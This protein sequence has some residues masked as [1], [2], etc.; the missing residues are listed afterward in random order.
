MVILGARTEITPEGVDALFASNAARFGKSVVEALHTPERAIH[1]AF[2][3]A[4]VDKN[5]I[6][7]WAIGGIPLKASPPFMPTDPTLAPVRQISG[8]MYA[9][10]LYPVVSKSRRS[11]GVISVFEDVTND[12]RV[13]RQSAVFNGVVAAL[14][15]VLTV[16][17]SAAYLR[18]VRPSAISCA[19]IPFS[20][21]GFMNAENGGTLI[22]GI[23][24]G[25]KVLGLEA[26]YASFKSAKPD[27]DRFEQMLRQILINAVGER[28]CA[29][30]TKTRFCSLHGKELCVVTVSPSS[31]PV[32]L[33]EENQRYCSRW[34]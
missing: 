10:L 6:L 11:V 5:G 1:E 30:W 32:F 27:R 18:R 3:Y 29:R 17:F 25:K 16:A 2:D 9:A 21:V 22:I 14:L 33:E 19:Q 28:R 13:L 26:D 8:K 12:Q 34:K 23:S 4:V 24:D 31:D 20:V 15:W 7:L